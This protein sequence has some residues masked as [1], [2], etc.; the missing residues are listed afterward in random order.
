MKLHALWDGLI[1]KKVT[2]D[3]RDLA[4]RLEAGI[5]QA[6]AAQWLAEDETQW[7]LESYAISKTTIYV[8]YSPGPQDMT[9]TNLGNAYFKQMRPIVEEQLRKAG[10]RLA[11]I[12]ED[13]LGGN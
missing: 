10:V 9:E 5:T 11:K 8:G 13:T 6:K 4:T 1:E 2:E 3:S 7:A 12:L